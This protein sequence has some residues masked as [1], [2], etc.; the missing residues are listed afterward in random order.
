[1]PTDRT[2]ARKA[3]AV[4]AEVLL[5]AAAGRNTAF[6]VS[7]QLEQVLAAVRGN[8]DLRNALCDR[9]IPAPSRA[10]IAREVFA[11]VD[12]ALV[13][14][15]AVMVE[16]DDISLLSRV[17]EAY[18]GLAEQHLGAVI[19]DVTTVVGLDEGLRG[20]IREKYSSQFGMDVLLREHIDRSLVGGIVLS[21]H[22]RRIDASVVSQLEN[23]RAVLS[24]S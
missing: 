23:A 7:G 14:V 21:T 5:E 9:T 1:M 11:G 8:V 2:F 20:R 4:Y 10:A 13:E 18:T 24:G 3:S 17:N 19:L 6:E 15:L 22:G 16:R 12:A